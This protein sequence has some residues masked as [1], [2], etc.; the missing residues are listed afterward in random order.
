MRVDPNVTGS[1]S[2]WL[3]MATPASHPPIRTAPCRKPGFGKKGARGSEPRGS[4]ARAGPDAMEP[5]GSG[6]LVL[7]P[8]LSF[9]AGYLDRM[10]TAPPSARGF[11]L[12]AGHARS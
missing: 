2:P 1:P 3:A 12:R 4:A 8:D 7:C 10:R 6:R 11:F 9:G 5:R